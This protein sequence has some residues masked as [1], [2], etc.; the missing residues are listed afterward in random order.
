MVIKIVADL[1]CPWC[2]LGLNR[3]KRAVAMRASLRYRF[4]WHSFLLNPDTPLAGIPLP[5]YTAA[6][7][8]D[9][10]SRLLG[11]IL[12]AANMD[13][14]PMNFSRIASVPNSI[15]AHRLIRW[16][17]S[18]AEDRQF[19]LISALYQAYFGE[20]DDIGQPR[21]LADIA[22]SVG[23]KWDAAARFLSGD[24]EREAIWTDYR[25]ARALGIKGV[26]CIIIDD[27]YAISGAQEPE[28]FLPLLDLA[29]A[30]DC[31]P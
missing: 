14:V 10:P 29:R 7:N 4:V 11:G 27:K 5:L 6:R 20:G 23:L 21:I 18:V 16:A 26:P 30:V 3:L 8:A 12:R 24:E 28:V 17:G 31:P 9:D 25:S 1:A 2:Y 15:N 13:G 19:D 22:A